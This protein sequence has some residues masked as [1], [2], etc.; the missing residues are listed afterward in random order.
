MKS[1]TRH[2]VSNFFIKR[3]LQ[4]RLIGKIVS[5]VLASTVVVVIT[6]LLIFYLRYKSSIFY[7]MDLEGELYK[8]SIIGILLPSLLVSALVNIVVGLGIGMY[9]SR[10]YAVPIYKLEQWAMLLK[11]GHLS[12]KLRFR[13]KEEMKELSDHCNTLSED[14]RSRF[15]RLRELVAQQV[16]RHGASQ[17]T[18]DMEKVFSDLELQSKVDVT[19]GVYSV[20]GQSKKPE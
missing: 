19:T 18:G 15:A 8:Q 13:E 14:Y 3:D 11:N 10:K 1:F 2:P 17:E 4:I 5:A 16:E 6:L 7:M 12:A 9:A 20:D